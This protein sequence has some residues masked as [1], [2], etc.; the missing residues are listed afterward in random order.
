[1]R[2]MM[3][4]TAQDVS[5]RVRALEQSE[6]E[7]TR[8]DEM[9]NYLRQ[10]LDDAQVSTPG[11]DMRSHMDLLTRANQDWLSMRNSA[12]EHANY[13]VRKRDYLRTA[14]HH[15]ALMV[16][17]SRYLANVPGIADGLADV[18]N[19]VRNN[20]STARAPLSHSVLA[21][22]IE[23]S[24]RTGAEDPNDDDPDRGRHFYIRRVNIRSGN[25]DPDNRPFDVDTDDEADAAIRQEQQ[26]QPPGARNAEDE[27]VEVMAAA[28]TL[29]REV[30]DFEAASAVAMEAE[31]VAA[32]GVAATVERGREE[33]VAAESTGGARGSSIRQIVRIGT[34]QDHRVH[35][36]QQEQMI[37]HHELSMIYP[38]NHAEFINGWGPRIRLPIYEAARVVA[39][40]HVEAQNLPPALTILPPT[41]ASRL[42][43]SRPGWTEVKDPP[44]TKENLR[45]LMALVDTAGEGM[46]K[47]EVLSEGCWLEMCNTLKIIWAQTEIARV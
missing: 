42:R 9:R 22:A 18:V 7:L 26:E 39:R 5:E 37:D 45:T 21:Q 43:D 12:E 2:S 34:A 25:V 47:G 31:R 19:A 15:A 24:R 8:L 46:R 23:S 44:T 30:A 1:L 28:E 36:S 40:E 38:A 20:R 4:E 35:H 3:A 33:M 10:V 13:C 27:A 32:T 41:P 16:E 17:S 29:T 11:T 14:T 6:F